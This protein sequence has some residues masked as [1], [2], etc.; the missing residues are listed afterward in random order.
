MPTQR[1]PSRFAA[2]SVVPLPANGS[3]TT[4]P[5]LLDARTIRSS[6]GSGIWQGWPV[7]SLNVPHTRGT[8]HVSVSGRNARSSSCGRST[9]VSSGS[10]P[11]G[12]AR[13]SA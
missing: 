13:R 6:T 9:H 10:L 4:S 12:L 1:R 11:L 8:Y 5:G 2:A 7:R 3:S